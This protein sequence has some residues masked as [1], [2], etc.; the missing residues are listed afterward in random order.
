VHAIYAGA[1][2]ETAAAEA[3]RL[4]IN[5]IFIGPAEIKAIR[6]DRLAKFD[7]RPELFRKVFENNLTRIY[8]VLGSR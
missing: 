5:Y 7:S 1:R 6:P 3:L 8:E 4:G 2:P